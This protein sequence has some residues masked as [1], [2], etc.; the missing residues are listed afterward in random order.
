MSTLRIR[1]F[2]SV[3]ISHTGNKTEAKITRTVQALLAYLLLNRDRIH[4]REVLADLFW[5]EQP[6]ERARSCLSTAL[7]RLRRVL[8]PEEKIKGTYLTTTPSGEVGF[9][10]ESEHWIDVAEFE[11]NASKWLAKPVHSMGVKDPGRLENTMELYRGELLEGL[12]DDWVIRER[13]R[14]RSLYLK[15]LAHLMQLYRHQ[16]AY[17]KSLLCG[18]R[19]IDH[20]PLREEI[21]REVMRLYVDSGQRALAL[22]QYKTCC[23]IL[24][25]ELGVRP[26][27]ETEALYRSILTGDGDHRTG[28]NLL[29]SQWNMAPVRLTGVD[30]AFETL[31]K[32]MRR[33]EESKDQLQRA[34]QSL[35]RALK[36]A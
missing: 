13:E 2:G 25:R 20:D 11:E 5:G 23:E 8:E 32:A 28:V 17:E 18:Q 9:N 4:P 26:M 35:E 24:N 3:R 10:V 12:Y 22:R 33:F 6:E 34:I 21:H 31:S 19:I 7:W 14:L 27:E 15:S 1:L 36:G 16:Q 29:Q 30:Q